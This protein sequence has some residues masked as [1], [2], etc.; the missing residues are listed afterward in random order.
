MAGHAEQA[1]RSFLLEVERAG[2]GRLDAADP[3]AQLGHLGPDARLGEHA[4][5]ERQRGGADVVAALD[6]QRERDRVQ[7]ALAEL[8]VRRRGGQRA[9]AGRA[10]GVDGGSRTVG[11]RPRE[12]RY[13]SI[14]GEVPRRCAASVMRM[15]SNLTI[16][17]QKQPI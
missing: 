2:G 17:C 10:A 1:E 15:T 8:P 14:R 11:S 12:S 13:R 3:P 7:I 6:R 4:Q 5:A 16:S 9:G